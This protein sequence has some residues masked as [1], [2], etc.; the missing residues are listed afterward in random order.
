MIKKEVI[1]GINKNFDRGV[2]INENS[3]DYALSK[4]KGWL[5]SLALLTRAILVDHV[6]E[7]GNKRTATAIIICF[8]NARKTDFN[9]NRLL[10]L[11]V[12]V[13]MNNI[14]DEK[15]IETMLK[16]LS[17]KPIS[18]KKNLTQQEFDINVI[19]ALKDY[20]DVYDALLEFEET[21]MLRLLKE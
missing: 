13:T 1:I 3:L 7:E 12:D 11:V 2:I 21:K 16:G 5:E 20:K 8:F 18:E 14:T 6:F 9:K 10:R 19:D 15:L 17:R 4:G